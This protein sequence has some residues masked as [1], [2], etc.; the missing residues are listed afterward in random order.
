[1]KKIVNFGMSNYCSLNV[2]FN[3]CQNVSHPMS[4]LVIFNDFLKYNFVTL[5]IVLFDI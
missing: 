1:M 2:F 3:L 5:K 4:N